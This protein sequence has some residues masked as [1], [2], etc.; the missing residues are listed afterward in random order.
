MDHFPGAGDDMA[1]R[2]TS[3]WLVRLTEAAGQ[4]GLAAG[5]VARWTRSVGE[6]LFREGDERAR[7]HGW[8]V[9]VRHGGLSR[10]YRDP[11]F[12]SL[13]ACPDCHGAGAVEQDHA[14]DR[15]SGTGRIRLGDRLSPDPGRGR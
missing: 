15:C 1:K 12:D 2:L 11:R 13:R 9:H 6:R 3:R 5:Y 7:R 10:V 14:C 8:Q 4:R